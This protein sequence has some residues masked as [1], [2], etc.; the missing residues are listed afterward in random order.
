MSRKKYQPTNAGKWEWSEAQTV[1][2]NDL[3]KCLTSLPILAYPD[4]TRPFLLHADA[5]IFGLGAVLCQRTGGIDRV[6]TYVSRGLSN[7]EQRYPV[8]KLEFLA[9]T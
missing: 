2:F 5:S 3:K 6:I 4:Y 9:L 7:A 1:A 8:H